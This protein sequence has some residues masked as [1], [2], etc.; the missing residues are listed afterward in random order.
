MC[1]KLLLYLLHKTARISTQWSII[2]SAVMDTVEYYTYRAPF[3]MT[4]LSSRTEYVRTCKVLTTTTYIR[5]TYMPY[6]CNISYF[7]CTYVNSLW[8]LSY[9]TCHKKLYEI[10]RNPRK[11][12][13]E[14]AKLLWNYPRNCSTISAESVSHFRGMI[15]RYPQNDTSM[16]AK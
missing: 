7:N 3:N 16:S 2:H 1:R 8:E 11:F 5:T 15:L 9:G 14:S 12:C 10:R 4:G 6:G 13:A